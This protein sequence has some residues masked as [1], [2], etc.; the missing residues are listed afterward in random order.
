MIKIKRAAIVALALGQ[1][2]WI[3]GSGLAIG[4]ASFNPGTCR[5]PYYTWAATWPIFY[6]APDAMRAWMVDQSFK[7]CGDL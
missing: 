5:A 1:A 4:G 6:V 2:I 3:C 7:L